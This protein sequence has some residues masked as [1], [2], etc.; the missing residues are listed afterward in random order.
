MSE[1]VA[2]DLDSQIIR[3]LHRNG[4]ASIQDLSLQLEV[5]RS[6][7]SS[8]LERL[9]SSGAVKVIGIVDPS[10]LGHHV[11]AHLSIKV[12]GSIKE[13]VKHILNAKETVLISVVGGEHSLVVEVWLGS[14]VELYALLEEFRS[15]ANIQSINTLTYSNIVKGFFMSNYSGQISLDSID[16]SIISLL[17]KDARIPFKTL[18]EAVHLSPTAVASRV[19]RLL[20]NHVIKISVVEARGFSRHQLSVGVGL[21]LKGSADS[22][23]EAIK[24]DDSIDFAAQTIGRFDAVATVVGSSPGAIFEKLDFYQSFDAVS[25]VESWTHLAVL[26]EDYTRTFGS[27]SDS[28]LTKELL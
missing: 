24:D 15:I 25:S 23:F 28:N 3:A 19:E 18:S 12:S 26:K 17:Q 20:N 21:R 1:I 27:F 9:R 10:F 2:T 14:T 16:I 22:V 5:S 8:R 11:L 7:V 6:I 13:A 4:R